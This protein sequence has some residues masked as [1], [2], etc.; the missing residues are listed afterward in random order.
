[1]F[2]VSWI[3]LVAVSALLALLA[4]WVI[5]AP[6]DPTTFEATTGVSWSSFS[7][8]SPKVAAYLEQEVRLLGINHVGVSLFAVAVAWIWLRT[9]DRRATAAL[10]ILPLTLGLTAALLFAGNVVGLGALY[11]VFAIVTAGA[12]VFADRA[13]ASG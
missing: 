6:V 11:A 5:S 13:L 4:L 3:T 1:M 12:V 8:T 10:L 9:G 7:S 2:R